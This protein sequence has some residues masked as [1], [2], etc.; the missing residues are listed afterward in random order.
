MFFQNVFVAIDFNQLRQQLMQ[1]N[2]LVKDLEFVVHTIQVWVG[3][4]FPRSWVEF[5][6]PVLHRM[7]GR[8]LAWHW[9]FVWGHVHLRS[10]SGI[11]CSGGLFFHKWLIRLWHWLLPLWNLAIEVVLANGVVAVRSSLFY[12]EDE[13]LELEFLGGITCEDQN[14]TYA[15]LRDLLTKEPAIMNFEFDFWDKEFRV[16]M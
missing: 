9:H 2:H 7:Y 6:A 11:V 12:L 1:P 4:T 3:Q 5:E 16:R 13:W 8:S 15:K 10:Q 14:V